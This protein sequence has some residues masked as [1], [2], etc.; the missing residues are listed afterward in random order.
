MYSAM[1]GM[2][3]VGILIYVLSRR[4]KENLS[5]PQA[6]VFALFCM[7]TGIVE[8]MLLSY[9][10]WS[11]FGGK[12]VFGAILLTPVVMPFLCR[13]LKLTSSQTLDLCAVCLAIDIAFSKLGCFFGGCC[14]GIILYVSG[15]YFQWPAQIIGSIVGFIVTFWLLRIEAVGKWR[16]GVYPLFMI[17]YGLMRF[18]LDRFEYMPDLWLGLRHSQW[19]G[20]ASA[21]IGIIWLVIYKK[22]INHGCPMCLEVEG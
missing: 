8:V 11:R 3:G 19:F 4:K 9:L 16:G 10:E 12:N 20:L 13:V 15:I 21:V 22:R 18:I 7:V 2:V 17:A 5:I 14:E 6:I 1:I